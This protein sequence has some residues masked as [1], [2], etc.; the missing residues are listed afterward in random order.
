MTNN[1]F[2][3]AENVF[4][5]AYG[6]E[7]PFSRQVK[8][9]AKDKLA[10]DFNM[11]IEPVPECAAVAVI[12]DEE[13]PAPKHVKFHI[14]QEVENDNEQGLTISIEFKDSMKCKYSEK[15]LNFSKINY[16]EDGT[17]TIYCVED[18]NIREDTSE[19][20]IICWGS[21]NKGKKGE[22]CLFVD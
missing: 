21:V 9:N 7:N 19:I 18:F 8:Y 11:S 10:I 12:F 22:I 1:N 2:L 13:H 6:P 15:L 20:C 4:P 3:N 14:S 5:F 17:A 16:A